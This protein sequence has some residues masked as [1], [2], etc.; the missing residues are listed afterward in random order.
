MNG[1]RTASFK[2]VHMGLLLDLVLLFLI[3]AVLAALLAVISDQLSAA[4]V[5]VETVT[6]QE[7]LASPS[8]SVRALYAFLTLQYCLAALCALLIIS[9]LSDLETSSRK[10]RCAKRWFLA[11]MAADGVAMLA[12][13]TVIM[14][15]HKQVLHPAEFASFAAFVLLVA[16]SGLALRALACGYGEV[17]ESIGAAELSQRAL[18]LSRRMALALAL[19]EFFIVASYCVSFFELRG[20]VRVL[21]LG[22]VLFA[23]VFFIFTRI[24]IT[25]CARKAAG[26]IAALSE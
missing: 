18:T 4:G 10:L 8:L 16:V 7:L 9:G 6:V 23:F 12:H 20:P 5:D 26:L 1:L 17:L 25:R 21:V 22:G 24:Q 14:L 13:I 15:P 2:R 3:P 19:T 11:L